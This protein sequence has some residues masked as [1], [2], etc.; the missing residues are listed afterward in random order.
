[1]KL[2]A[3]LTSLLLLPPLL[4]GAT[5]LLDSDLDGVEDAKDLCPNTPFD[6]TVNSHGCGE[7]QSPFQAQRWSLQLGVDYS[8][9]T[10]YESDT[11]LNLYIRYDYHQWDF[12]L[13]TTNQ[14]TLSSQT[15]ESE[16]D[17]YLTLGYKLPPLQN[18]TYI[19]LFGGTKFAFTDGNSR[20]NDFFFGADL[21]YTYN[22]QT[23]LFGYYSYTFSGDSNEIAYK[24][25]ATLSVGAGYQLSPKWYGSL[26]YTY[27][28]ETYE[29][30]QSS[31][32]LSVL[33]RYMLNNTFYL[34]MG[35]THGL[36]KANYDNTF[37]FAIGVSFE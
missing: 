20:D 36:N 2:Y 1:M 22:R 31:R 16:D 24:D 9:D 28:G 5:P 3:V 30:A 27:V 32:S 17:L 18:Q 14:S 34:S 8:T 15:Q 19:H 26:S 6:A 23:T 7:S 25:F 29:G 35:Y 4:I 37:S 33:G 11:L 12:A 10:A 21:S 13:S